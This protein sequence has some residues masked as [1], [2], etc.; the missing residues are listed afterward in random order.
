MSQ[1]GQPLTLYTI[2]HSTHPIEVFVALLTAHQIQAVADVR[3]VP[4]SRHNPQF[5]VDNLPPAL[6]AA[7]IK[8]VFL[9]EELGARRKE[10]TSYSHG[11]VDYALLAQNPLF[12]HGLQRLKNGAEK[13]R[14][15]IMCAEKDPLECHRAIL[16]A[17]EA[18]PL[19]AAINHI[20]PDGSLESHAHAE[21]RLLALYGFTGHELFAPHQEQLA[22]AYRRRAEEIAFQEN[23]PQAVRQH[24]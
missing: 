7:G 10:R 14:I 1:S 12:Q 17:R 13:M 20:L 21:E 5:D 22:E 9:G 6:K 4:M 11:K 16:V 2:G 19:F 8:Y 23:P 3:S 24:G 18:K 15:A